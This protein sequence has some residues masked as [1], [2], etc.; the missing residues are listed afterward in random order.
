MGN[1]T[2][3]GYAKSQIANSE[4]IRKDCLSCRGGDVCAFVNRCHSVVSVTFSDEYSDL[5]LLGIDFVDVI[6]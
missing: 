4:I 2:T 5:E 6:P 1:W 3:H